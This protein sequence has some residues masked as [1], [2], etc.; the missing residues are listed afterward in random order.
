MLCKSSFNYFYSL[1]TTLRCTNHFIFIIDLPNPTNKATIAIGRSLSEG[2]LKLIGLGHK[3]EANT[4]R[5]SS[6]SSCMRAI[7]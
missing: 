1:I 4:A 5:I 6:A 2:G 7:P 3:T